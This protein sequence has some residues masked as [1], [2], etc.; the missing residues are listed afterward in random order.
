MKQIN[1][2]KHNMVKNPNWYE[3]NLLAILQ[4]WPRIWAWDYREQS[5]T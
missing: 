1:K 5:G 4:A 2:M 3:L